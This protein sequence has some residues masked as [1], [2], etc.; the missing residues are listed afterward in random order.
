MYCTAAPVIGWPRLST[1]RPVTT[2]GLPAG[3]EAGALI[4]NAGTSFAPKADGGSC[5]IS[6]SA[7]FA[8]AV[9]RPCPSGTILSGRSCVVW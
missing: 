6:R 1:S 2:S 8:K 9:T 7:V 5:W 3:T 4:V